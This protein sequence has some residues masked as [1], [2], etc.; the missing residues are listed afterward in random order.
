MKVIRLLQVPTVL[1]DLLTV[2]YLERS[3]LKRSHC[4]SFKLVLKTSLPI[5][6]LR[7]PTPIHG[8]FRYICRHSWADV[9]RRLEIQSRV[10]FA[11]LRQKRLIN[12]YGGG[13]QLPGPGTPQPESE[14]PESESKGARM[15]DPPPSWKPT[16]FKMIESA[17][18]TMVSLFVLGYSCSIFIGAYTEADIYVSLAGYGYHRYYKYLVLQKVENAFKPGG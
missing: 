14:E 13:P 7:P 2:H 12:G 10:N 4:L 3:V 6:I 17:A 15:N 5:M 18:T 1:L 16:L 8:A 9:R 11:L